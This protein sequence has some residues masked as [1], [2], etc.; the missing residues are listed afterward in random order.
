MNIAT[1]NYCGWVITSYA[2]AIVGE[3]DQVIY[4]ASAVIKRFCDP[5][6]DQA[7]AQKQEDLRRIYGVRGRF[8]SERVAREIAVSTAKQAIDRS[9]YRD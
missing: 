7:L 2:K 3:D 9:K 6:E 4:E 5:S 1:V 8:T